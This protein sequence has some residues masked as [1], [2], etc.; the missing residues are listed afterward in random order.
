MS[1]KGRGGRKSRRPSILASKEASDRLK[2]MEELGLDEEAYKEYLKMPAREAGRGSLQLFPSITGPIVY[3]DRSENQRIHDQR[4]TELR[5]QTQQRKK[6]AEARAAVDNRAR[7]RGE[8]TPTQK[9][10]KAAEAAAKAQAEAAAKAKAQVQTAATPAPATPVRPGPAGGSGDPIPPPTAKNQ[11]PQIPKVSAVVTRGPH[12]TQSSV[13]TV[14]GKVVDPND[15]QAVAHARGYEREAHA[16]HVRNYFEQRRREEIQAIRDRAQETSKFYQQQRERYAKENYDKAKFST[17]EGWANLGLKEGEKSGAS[18]AEGSAE[19]KAYDER[20]E[21][22]RKALGNHAKMAAKYGYGASH[23]IAGV[24]KLFEEGAKAGTLSNKQLDALDKKTE[25]WGAEIRKKKDFLDRRMAVLAEE[26]ARRYLGDAGKGLGRE[27]A[28]ALADSQRLAAV[29]GAAKGL[30]TQGLSEADRLKH[31]ETLLRHGVDAEA[32]GRNRVEQDAALRTRFLRDAGGKTDAD[33]FSRLY[34]NYGLE[35]IGKAASF[36]DIIGFGTGANGTGGPT[37]AVTEFNRKR[38]ANGVLQ[39]ADTTMDYQKTVRENEAAENQAAAEQAMTEDLV[40]SPQ[41]PPPSPLAPRTAEDELYQG[42]RA[43]RR[44]GFARRFV[45]P[46]A[47][48]P[49]G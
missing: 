39:A 13:L 11:G 42:R 19:R 30:G 6:A 32:I 10:Q 12:G 29:Q 40:S 16:Q 48:S 34:R 23:N 41:T 21:A 26:S 15:P 5:Q 1:T 47:L 9:E 49:R 3:D 18:F 38:G 27:A 37:A 4:L 2:K 24:T 20:V 36:K 31:S 43:A 46:T 7:I 44:G 17:R 8:E 14:D 28:I 33:T 45:N 35:S 22:I 25:A